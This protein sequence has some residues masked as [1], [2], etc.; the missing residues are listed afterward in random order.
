MTTGTGASAGATITAAGLDGVVCKS[1]EVTASYCATSSVTARDIPSGATLRLRAGDPIRFSR[2][3]G[4]D[5]ICAVGGFA[6]DGAGAMYAFSGGSCANSGG[7]SALTVDGYRVGDVQA[8]FVSGV[9]GAFVPFV[10][11]APSVKWEQ[12]AKTLAPANA[13]SAV[14]ATTPHGALTWAS[15]NGTGLV[16]GGSGTEPVLRPGDSGSPM[17]QGSTLV[18]VGSNDRGLTPAA[19]ITA[20][21]SKLGAGV[22]FAT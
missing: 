18:G 5:R 4:T 22:Q 15:V 21:M 11:L 7:A 20:A 17:V 8:V 14:S 3:D 1:A 13:S 19:T 9:G 12:S 10:K 6:R 16:W 2:A